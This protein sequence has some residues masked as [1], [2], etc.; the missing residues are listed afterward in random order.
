[1][2]PLSSPKSDVPVALCL[3]GLDPSGGAG[4]LRD[5]IT[6]ASLGVHP[7]A[8]PLAETIQNGSGC[9]SIEAPAASP[10]LALEA[11]KPH[12]GGG[13]GLKVG[14]SALD[15]DAF[16]SV[17]RGLAALGPA[18]QIWDPILAP[19]LGVSLH[20]GS[21]LRRMART[22]LSSGEWVVCPN[23]MEARTFS[24]HSVPGSGW[25][26]GEL[27][28]PL[29]EMG[30]RAVWLKGGHAGGETVED[31][32]V[33][34]AGTQSLGLF[35]RLSG[36]RRGTGCTLA[37]AWLGY[38]LRGLDDLDAARAAVAWLREGWTPCFTPGGVGRPCFAPRSAC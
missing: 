24:G 17:A 22:L 4:L 5:A 9:L 1:M 20:D 14:M 37:S 30:A 3:G 28:K 29:L 11:L 34:E 18:V 7:M 25:N 36:E 31:L 2:L 32:W 21:R 26:S 35:P 15:E 19:S 10:V 27:A 23:V 38:R 6:L 33:T 12:L 8:I 13:W 16:S